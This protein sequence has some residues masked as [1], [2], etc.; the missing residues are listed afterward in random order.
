MR[1]K[2]KLPFAAWVVA[3]IALLLAPLALAQGNVQATQKVDPS[4]DPIP[5]TLKADPEVAW[6]SEPVTLMG[7][8]A[9][10]NGLK[11]VK[12]VVTPPTNAG[13]KPEPVTL[14]TTLD[15]Y[16]D[17]EVD[18]TRT[19]I[20]GLYDVVATAPDGRG[21]TKSQFVIYSAPD[22]QQDVPGELVKAA[23][24]Y[25]DALAVRV[26]ALPPSPAKEQAKK[27]MAGLRTRARALKADNTAMTEFAKVIVENVKNIEKRKRLEQYR[28]AAVQS[29]DRGKKLATRSKEELAKLN[30]RRTTCDDL[31]V[32]VEG[33]KFTAVLLNFV[34]G[35]LEGLAANWG[36]ELL[37]VAAETAVQKAGAGGGM[38]QLTAGEISRNIDA[39]LLRQK[40]KYNVASGINA[41]MTKFAESIMLDYCEVFAGP[42]SGDM[43]ARF[44]EQGEKWWSYDYKIFGRIVLHYPNDA[45]GER[46]PLKGRIEGV[47]YDFHY[48]EN[49]LSVL[50]PNL[51]SS[52]VQVKKGFLPFD[53]GAQYATE[54]SKYVEGSVVGAMLP[55]AFFIAIEGEA[56][57]D[58]LFITIGPARTDIDA[59]ARVVAL[60]LSPLSL[61]IIPTAYELPYKN[62]RFLIERATDGMVLTLPIKTRGKTMTVEQDFAVD[63]RGGGDAR[64]DYTLKLKAC[65]PDCSGGSAPR[66]G[67]PRL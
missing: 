1:A 57:K 45:S 32:I 20:N 54:M 39:V 10:V 8:S 16:G 23:Q 64:A 2:E 65:N 27:E 51:A 55:N 29:Y 11:T 7:G 31:E 9:G 14:Y 12:L 17:Y 50:Y 15:A 62:A 47:A 13:R 48:W 59:K 22:L 21:V 5:I 58:N 40:D 37:G 19:L 60:T 44:F 28:R 35:N 36:K 18:F 53:G 24:T 34:A 4:G 61:A 25:L 56:T 43:H 42:I 3:G 63:N 26:E 6:L 38:V 66:G 49:A 67:E 41:V 46:I 52:A 30:Q 33:L